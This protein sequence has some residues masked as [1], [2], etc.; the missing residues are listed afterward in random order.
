MKILV[1]GTSD[2]SGRFAE[3]ET[4]AAILAAGVEVRL[5]QPVELVEVPFTV[6]RPADARYAERK[7]EEHEPDVVMLSVGTAMFTVGFVSSRVEALFGQ[8]AARRYRRWEERF[9]DRTRGR[10]RVADGL[11]AA[12]R[13]VARTIIGTKTMSPEKDVTEGFRAVVDAIARHEHVQAVFVAA[14]PIGAHHH[15]PGAAERRRRFLSAVER[16]VRERHF[17]SIEAEDAY[18]GRLSESEIKPRDPLH[19]GTEGHRVLGEYLVEAVAAAMAAK[20]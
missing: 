11:N 10:G 8:R 3:G 5:G 12:A 20:V 4:W 18:R 9:D 6:L 2:T 15:R 13:R 16:A 7:I 19:Q 17:T 1:L 14:A